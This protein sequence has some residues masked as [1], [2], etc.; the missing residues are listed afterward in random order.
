MIEAIDINYKVNGKIICNNINLKFK[1][2]IMTGIIGPNGS[3]KSTFLKQVYG[4]LEPTSGKILYE[5]ENIDKYSS[6]EMAKKIGVMA[7]ESNT[8]FSFTVG[9]IVL[10]GRAPYL[11]FYGNY[12]IEDFELV[13]RALDMVGLIDKLEQNFS[14]LSGGEKQRVLLARLLTQDTPVL[15]LDEPTNHL[16]IGYQYKVLDI[17][18][19]LNKTIIIAIHD[20]N[21]A[22]KYCDEIVLFNEGKVIKKGQAKEVLDP[23]ILKNI[24]GIR[25]E[26][27]IKDEELKNIDILGAI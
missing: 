14:T 12:T 2:D 18:R 5:G 17:L 22:I 10:M 27:I 3:G 7:Q 23:Q 25:C 26:L 6:K 4:V 13:R 1:K 21:F 9:E 20:L 19:D 11:D 8:E 24:F 15:I 16:D